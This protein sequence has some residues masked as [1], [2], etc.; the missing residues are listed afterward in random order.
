M[1]RYSD[2]M[3]AQCMA[4]AATV[5]AG[6]TGLRAWLAAAR[7]RWVTPVRLKRLTAGLLA[8]AVAIVSVGAG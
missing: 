3:C 1:S 6:A 4:S 8:V 2:G 5:A 7:F